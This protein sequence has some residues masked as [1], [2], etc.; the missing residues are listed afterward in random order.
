MN[1]TK[2]LFYVIPLLLLT[3]IPLYSNGNINNYELGTAIYRN[4]GPNTSAEH[5]HS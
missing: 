5:W 3:S 2:I 4:L 1:R